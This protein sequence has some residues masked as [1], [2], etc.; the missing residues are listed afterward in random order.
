MEGLAL[1][2][3]RSGQPALPAWR[4]L[5]AVPSG[6]EPVLAFARPVIGGRHTLRLYPHQPSRDDPDPRADDYKETPPP[7]VF[8]AGQPFVK[9]VIAYSTNALFPATPCTVNKLRGKARDLFVAVV[10]CAAGQYN[11]VT[12]ALTLFRSVDAQI[13]F[14]GGS[15]T[16]VPQAALGSFEPITQSYRGA[17]LNESAIGR[18]AVED[19]TQRLCAGEEFLIL[20]HPKYRS[21]ADTLA[22]FKTDRGIPSR[23]FNVNDGAGPGPDTKESIDAFIESRYAR[24]LVRPSYVLL[25]GDSGDIPTWLVQNLTKPSG[26]QIATDHPYASLGSALALNDLLPDFALGRIP[27]N[28]A[29]EAQNVVDK[30]IK[31]EGQP[32][33]DASFYVNAAIAAYFECCRTDAGAGREDG[34]S[35]IRRAEYVRTQLMLAGYQAKRIYNTSPKYH[36]E[37][38][39]DATPRAYWDGDPLP[40]DLLPASSFPWNGHT[41]DIIQAFNAGKSLFFHLDHGYNGGWGDPPFNKSNVAGLTNGDKLPVVFNLNCSSGGFDSDSFSEVLLKQAG[42]GAIGV[43][44]WTRVSNTGYYGAVLKGALDS[45]WPGTLPDFGG[46]WPQPRLGDV[47]NSSKLLMAS[48]FAGSDMASEDYQKTLN[49]IRM[50]HL[51]GDPTLAAWTGD[52]YPIGMHVVVIPKFDRIDITYPVNDAVITVAQKTTGGVVPIARGRV[53]N[54]AASLPYVNTPLV[55]V[56]LTVSATKPN[57]ISQKLSVR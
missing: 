8:F 9:D 45:F 28:T 5:V 44:G 54:G 38:S 50:Y 10:E 7:A 55:N 43:Y 16:F 24:C 35:F 18:Y 39:L 25:L 33:L 4:R 36:P 13:E 27:V 19:T 23:V 57:A 52:P 1:A 42:G 51:F 26:S 37:Y 2:A 56:P 29:A 32:L 30:I 53:T 49:H 40:A 47:L 20:T 3:A 6:A 34:R 22:T 15:G 46:P 12:Q 11:P 48:T 41:Q 14:H 31:Y 21:A 17:M